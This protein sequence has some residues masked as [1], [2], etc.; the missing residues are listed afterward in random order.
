MEFL[1]DDEKNNRFIKML[2]AIGLALFVV[3]FGLPL[4][5]LVLGD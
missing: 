3:L 5:D 2:V 1:S 4:L